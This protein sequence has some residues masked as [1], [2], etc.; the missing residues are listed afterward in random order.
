MI[1]LT[2]EAASKVKELLAQRKRDDLALR[3]F[4]QPG[5][6]SGFTYG[7][8]LDAGR[9]DDDHVIEQDGVRVVV[10]SM[11]ARFL[12]GALI[13]YVESLSG[14]GFTIHNPNAVQTCG[15]GSS[16]RTRDEAGQ[17]RS[18]DEPAGEER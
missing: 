17:P 9:G 13:D 5:G 14:S 2:P 11:S 18:C 15:C 12:R 3:V 7:L 10:D 16:F 1:T 4:V 6:C 8:A